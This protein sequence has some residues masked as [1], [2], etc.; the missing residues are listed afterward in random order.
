MNKHLI[1]IINNWNP[2]EL[3]PLLEDEYYPEI[4]KIQ[5]FMDDSNDLTIH[6]L[7]AIIEYIFISAFAENI[8]VN[9][10]KEDC[11]KIAESI[12]RTNI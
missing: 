11:E 7:A 3:Y 2:A 6:K 5:S 4:T 9:S 12:L 1:E 8:V 10:F